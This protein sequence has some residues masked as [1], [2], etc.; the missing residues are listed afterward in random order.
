[1][2]DAGVLELFKQNDMFK[3]PL[4]VIVDG[5]VS[6]LTTKPVHNTGILTFNVTTTEEL[7]GFELSNADF[8]LDYSGVRALFQLIAQAICHSPTPNHEEFKAKHE[9]HCYVGDRPEFQD[10][11]ASVMQHIADIWVGYKDGQ[12]WLAFLDHDNKLPKVRFMMDNLEN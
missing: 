7:S 6:K 12:V 10:A 4:K 11:G 9:M 3:T 5:K 2:A 8:E 1:M